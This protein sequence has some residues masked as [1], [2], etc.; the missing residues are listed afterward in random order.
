M[1]ITPLRTYNA[2]VTPRSPRFAAE[3]RYYVIFIE[4]VSVRFVLTRHFTRSFRPLPMYFKTSIRVRSFLLFLFP[5]GREFS[6]KYARF[7]RHIF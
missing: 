2:E 5:L 4:R 7:V 3:R 6:I 1:I